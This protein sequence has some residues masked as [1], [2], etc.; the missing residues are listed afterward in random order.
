[1][2]LNVHLSPDQ[3]SALAELQQML[4]AASKSETVRRAIVELRDARK[5][6]SRAQWQD[7]HADSNSKV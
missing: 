6:L 3:V 2:R 4:D 1:M 7:Y 5:M